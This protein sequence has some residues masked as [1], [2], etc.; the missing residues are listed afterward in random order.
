MKSPVADPKDGWR[1]ALEGIRETVQ[2][3]HPRSLTMR[4]MK[5]AESSSSGA[6]AFGEATYVIDRMVEGH[7]ARDV[8]T[9]ALRPHGAGRD[10]DDGGDLLRALPGSFG[11]KWMW[12]PIIVTPPVIVA[13]VMGVFSRKW[14]KTVLPVTAI[15]YTANGLLGEFFHA[16]GV[17]AQAWRLGPRLLQRADGSPDRRP[18]ADDHG[19]RHGPA[20]RALAPRGRAS[21]VRDLSRPDHLPNLREGRQP[22]NRRGFPA[23]V[24]ASRRR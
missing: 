22:R 17:A 7:P 18:R 4:A 23:S 13:G 6:A 19:R 14:A 3:L 24:E 16:R 12:S 11:N 1:G 20:G 21:L 8:R 5:E 9:V 2:N 15:I 10:G